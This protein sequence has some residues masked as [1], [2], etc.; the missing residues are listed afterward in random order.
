M[1]GGVFVCGGG[2]PKALWVTKRACVKQANVCFRMDVS[3]LTKTSI[4]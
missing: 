4:F 3:A 2:G 1:C